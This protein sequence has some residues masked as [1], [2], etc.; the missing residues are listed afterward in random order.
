M[1]KSKG[2]PLTRTWDSIYARCNCPNAVNYA[3][4]GGKGVELRLTRAE[5]YDELGDKPFPGATVERIDTKGHYERGNIKWAT[6]KEQQN[7]R[8]NNRLLTLDDCTQ[9]IAQWADETGISPDLIWARIFR[10]GWSVERALT[11]PTRRCI[12]RW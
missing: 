7:N 8:S 3:R 10:L 5:L 11:T 12:R 9:T 4:Y 2:A 6:Q 1:P